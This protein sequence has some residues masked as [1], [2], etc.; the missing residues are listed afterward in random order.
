MNEFLH[1]TLRSNNINV[2][3]DEKIG[4]TYF[5]MD[6][7]TEEHSK[8]HSLTSLL[9]PVLSKESLN[10]IVID[11]G[12]GTSYSGSGDER[13][14]FSTPGNMNEILEREVVKYKGLL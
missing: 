8:S 9:N 2:K 14:S 11:E 3:L 6:K 5:N 4:T 7:M 13:L 1:A 12:S 10:S